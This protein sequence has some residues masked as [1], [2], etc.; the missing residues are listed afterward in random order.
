MNTINTNT[1]T[2]R[3]D[4][5][6]PIGVFL[7]LR[8]HYA[9]VSLFES[10]DFTSRE[11][12]KSF[13]GVNSL[14]TLTSSQRMVRIREKGLE[15]IFFETDDM[16]STITQFFNSY[17]FSDSDTSALN[18]F[19]GALAYDSIPQ[20]ETLQFKTRTR[21]ESL[22][23]IYLNLFQYLLVF[24]NFSNQIL[25]LSNGLNAE[26]E[27][28]NELEK[29][30]SFPSFQSSDFR[31]IGNLL[32]TETDQTF[33]LKV[34]LAKNNIRNGDVF[35]LVLSRGY[36]QAFKGDEFEVYR[37]LR[38]INPSP[39][40]FYFDM[41]KA[42]L[43]G[44]SPEAQ[45]KLT[46]RKAEIHPIAGTMRRTGEA[47]KDHQ[48]AI[49]LA[50]DAKENAEHIMLVDLA[51]N[52]LNATCE[53]VRVADFK[54][55]QSFSHVIHMVSRVEG[56]LRDFSPFTAMVKTFPAGTLS[57]APKYKAMELIDQYEEVNRG[58]YGGA[59]GHFAANGNINIAIIIRSALSYKKT[60]Y[61]Q[62]GA[63]IVLD[64]SPASETEEVKNKVG[65]VLKA[66]QRANTNE[67]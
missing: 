12:S 9:N 52:D 59:I 37:Q 51:R 3:G 57:G 45:F 18:G 47:V 27:N 30:L 49:Q 43:L 5:L 2:L 25:M 29:I 4:M 34:E 60:L 66:I 56:E 67:L 41:E 8:N 22:P 17:S 58:F 13:I 26:P 39:Y 16:E 44:T 6:T 55:I 42:R 7:N 48:L 15:E 11:N 65:A 61:T 32:S 64:S 53:D 63:G 40:M 50:N 28:F 38:S 33:Q 31:T 10:S 35:Q 20:F 62:A 36:S 54:S 46:N 19:F 14:V 1:K 24:D 21:F 23:D